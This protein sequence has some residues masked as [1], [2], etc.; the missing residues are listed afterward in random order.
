MKDTEFDALNKRVQVI[1]YRAMADE[2]NLQ[3]LNAT[4]QE[5]S[6]RYHTVCRSLNN[7]MARIKQLED[8]MEIEPWDQRNE[9]HDRNNP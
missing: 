3:S 9:S 8:A 6:N 2:A 1:F 5:L 7:A 4:V